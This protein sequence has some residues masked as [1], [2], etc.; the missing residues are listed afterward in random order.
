M[1]IEEK[2]SHIPTL[3]WENHES[4]F[5][6]QQVKFR[7]KQVFF[8]CEQALEKYAKVATVGNVTQNLEELDQNLHQDRSLSLSP[9]S[10]KLTTAY[11]Q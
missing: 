3:N 5:L 4:W 11:H 8:T 1:A 9:S 10:F 6:R 2:G 7:G